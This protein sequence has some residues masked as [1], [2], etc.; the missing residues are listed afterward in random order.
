MFK[1][2]V[3]QLTLHHYICHLLLDLIQRFTFLRI[4]IHVDKIFKTI[5]WF[6]KDRQMVILEKKKTCKTKDKEMNPLDCAPKRICLYINLDQ[7]LVNV[8]THLLET[9]LYSSPFTTTLCQ[10]TYQ[11]P[12]QFSF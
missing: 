3:L 12:S 5:G 8:M 2:L 4:F 7:N 11:H 6:T 9:V 1:T 10:L